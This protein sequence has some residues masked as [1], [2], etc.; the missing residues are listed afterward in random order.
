[1]EDK[2][3][4][5]NAI[6]ELELE[7]FLNVAAREKA[8][9]QEHPDRF[10]AFRT[11]NFCAWSEEALSSYHDDLIKAKAN[12]RN[13]L[14][15]KYARMEGIIPQLTDSPLLD[16]IVDIEMEWVR[17]LAAQYPNIHSK[18]RPIEQDGP[19]T[20][21]IRTYLRGE[22]ETF[23]EKT[24]E[25]YYQNVVNSRKH[26]TNLARA[27]LQATIRNAGFNSLDE[28]EAHLAAQHNQTRQL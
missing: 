18:G 7:M 10:R 9:C 16:A 4:I 13:L 27:R 2:K 19:H 20:T 17:E 24:L 25:L 5:I 23:S 3:D 28:A 15:L 14:T 8:S 11:S 26:G 1:M 21:S 22:L 6:I 12:D